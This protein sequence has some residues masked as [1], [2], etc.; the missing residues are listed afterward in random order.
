MDKEIGNFEVG[1]DFDA[2]VVDTS[3]SIQGLDFRNDNLEERLQ[4]FIYSGDDRS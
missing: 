3:V 2:L 4:R 1:K